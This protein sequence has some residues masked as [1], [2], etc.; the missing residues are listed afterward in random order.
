MQAEAAVVGGMADDSQ[1]IRQG[2]VKQVVNIDLQPLMGSI[3][4]RLRKLLMFSELLRFPS[5]IG[6]HTVLRAV[7]NSKLG[8]KSVRAKETLLVDTTYLDAYFETTARIDDT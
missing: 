4:D 6:R 7:L 1:T 5:Q 8:I 2:Q 3:F